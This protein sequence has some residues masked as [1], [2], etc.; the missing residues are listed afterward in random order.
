MYSVGAWCCVAYR[1][2]P[3]FWSQ[4][5]LSY[6]SYGWW[7]VLFGTTCFPLQPLS[8]LGS[9]GLVLAKGMEIT[10]SA[11]SKSATL[12]SKKSSKFSVET[13]AWIEMYLQQKYAWVGFS[14][15]VAIVKLKHCCATVEEWLSVCSTT[16]CNAKGLPG[17]A[18]TRVWA[19]Q[20]LLV[21]HCM[22]PMWLT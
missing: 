3:V 5:L 7:H 13:V 12:S 9:S 17:E 15:H 11:W 14:S 19:V 8:S 10:S 4:P 20:K 18:Q 22:M 21:F 6:V 2:F 1:P 16:T